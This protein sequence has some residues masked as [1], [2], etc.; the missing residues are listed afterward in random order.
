MIYIYIIFNRKCWLDLPLNAT[1]P[2]YNNCNVFLKVLR[3]PSHVNV[4]INYQHYPQRE[5]QNNNINDNSNNTERTN[6]KNAFN[7][8]ADLDVSQI[9][10]ELNE[11]WSKKEKIYSHRE[12]N[13]NNNNHQM[14]NQ[15]Q[16]EIP[17]NNNIGEQGDIN[18]EYHNMY[19][20]QH[21]QGGFTQNNETEWGNI[22]DEIKQNLQN[23]KLHKQNTF[24][25]NN[26]Y[27]Y[28]E[29]QQQ[30]QQQQPQQKQQPNVDPTCNLNIYI[31]INYIVEKVFQDIPSSNPPNNYPNQPYNN[32]QYQQPQQQQPQFN[33]YQQPSQQQQQPPPQQSSQTNNTNFLD[34]IPSSLP[35]SEIRSRIDYVVSNWEQGISGKKNLLF[36]LSTLGDLW[37]SPS[38]EKASMQDLVQNPSSVRSYYKKAMRELHP[39]KNNNKDYKIKYLASCLYQVL[40]E[41]NTSYNS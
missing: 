5:Q 6:A 39:D 9:R 7:I 18:N 16:T 11:N 13:N 26:P 24:N 31:T 35:E 17:N 3:V 41:A 21:N 19:Y 29:R 22:F 37:K 10:R 36:L 25:A 1:V 14:R 30:Q 20:S 8:P 28:Q 12:S 27:I 34:L 15:F 2:V 4:V 32:N 38:F 33:T 40:N 23:T